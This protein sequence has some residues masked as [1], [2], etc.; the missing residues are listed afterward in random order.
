[1]TYQEAA[2]VSPI[3]AA[4]NM[5]GSRPV[6]VRRYTG[7]GYRTWVQVPGSGQWEPVGVTFAATVGVDRNAWKPLTSR[8]D[9]MNW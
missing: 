1:M 7:H 9:S 8:P 5:T 2:D 6:I 3:D 4:I